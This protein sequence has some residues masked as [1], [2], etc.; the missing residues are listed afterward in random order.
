MAGGR[1]RAAFGLAVTAAAGAILL[2]TG[3]AS[4]TTPTDRATVAPA[5]AVVGQ[6]YEVCADHL[7]LRTTPEPNGPDQGELYA[8]SHVDVER[9]YA[10]GMLYVMA[11][12]ELNRH[13]YVDDGHFCGE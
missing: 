13:G 1:G 6:R 5:G 11:Y 8:G 2:G 3:S 10:N 9:T 4:A 12:G 7:A